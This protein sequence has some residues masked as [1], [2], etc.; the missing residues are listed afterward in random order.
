MTNWP[1]TP[2]RKEKNHYFIL[3]TWRN[4]FNNI[5][6]VPE[7]FI[8]PSMEIDELLSPWSHSISDVT[9]VGYATVRNSKYKDAWDLL[10]K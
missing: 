8:V 10:N 1:L 7:V 4:K 6:S 9:C 3:V 2:K 5:G